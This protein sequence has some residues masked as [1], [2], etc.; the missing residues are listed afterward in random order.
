VLNWTLERTKRL[1]PEAIF[2]AIPEEKRRT[3]HGRNR[4][5]A[6]GSGADAVGERQP[7]L[8][9]AIGLVTG[10]ARHMAVGAQSRVK[11]QAP[12]EICGARVIGDAVGRVPRE[13]VEFRERQRLDLLELRIRPTATARCGD[14]RDGCQQDQYGH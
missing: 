5:G 8:E 2:A 13:R 9:P 12:P 7:V 3:R 1:G 4:H 10:A 11:E 14:G 6:P